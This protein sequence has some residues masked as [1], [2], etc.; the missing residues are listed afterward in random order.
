MNIYMYVYIHIYVCMYIYIYTYVHIYTY[1]YIYTYVCTYVY[2]YL[3][4]FNIYIGG[5]SYI[6]CPL[7][8]KACTYDTNNVLISCAEFDTN[9][10]HGYHLTLNVIRY[11]SNLQVLNTYL[12]LYIYIYTYIHLYIYTYI[13]TVLEGYIIM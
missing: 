7:K 5:A 3:Y 1:V 9:I 2:L 4:I 10:L 6:S 13:F 12:Y 8:R 11:T